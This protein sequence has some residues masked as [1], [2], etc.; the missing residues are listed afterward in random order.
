MTQAL[1][2]QSGDEQDK[3][4][5]VL[6]RKLASETQ[7]RNQAENELERY[8]IQ[9]SKQN[10]QLQDSV[11]SLESVKR[12]LIQS[13]KMASL[14]QLTAGIAHEINNPVAFIRSNM[15]VLEDYIKSYKI[16]HDELKSEC[17]KNKSLDLSSFNTLCEKVDLAYIDKD[18]ADL[19][20]S[21]IEGLNRVRDIVDNVKRF[22]HVSDCKL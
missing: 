10:L 8:S 11:N 22:S 15:Q 7:A 4:I 5:A 19:L 21:N 14:G 20:T 13:N 12:Q 9:I 6:E 2:P 17:V 1:Q 3:R 18:A 16:L